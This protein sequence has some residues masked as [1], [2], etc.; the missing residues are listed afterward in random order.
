MNRNFHA[1]ILALFLAAISLSIFFHKVFATDVPLLPNQAYKNWYVEA[2]LSVNSEGR[3]LDSENALPSEIKL[4]LP[5]SS[6]GYEIKILST[7]T[8]VAKSKI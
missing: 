5:Q 2:K 8:I 7:I 6:P 4:Q 1:L 3:I